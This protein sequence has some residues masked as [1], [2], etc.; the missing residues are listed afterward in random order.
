MDK[1]EVKGW[2]K[3][4]VGK[5]NR[6]ELVEGWYDFEMYVKVKVR[7]EEM[8]LGMGW[9]GDVGEELSGVVVVEDDGE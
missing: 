9:R 1:W 4:F 8:G 2:W 6:G 7:V 3:S 5:W